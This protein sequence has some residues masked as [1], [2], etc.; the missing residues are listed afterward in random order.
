MMEYG[1]AERLTLRMGSQVSLES[2]T[3]DCRNE[4][5]DGI[6]GTSGNRS[7][8]SH[9]APSFSQYGINC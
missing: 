3:I 9:V 2:E 7:V 6:Q 8:L 4:C 1:Q 5:F